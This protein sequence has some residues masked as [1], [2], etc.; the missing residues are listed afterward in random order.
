MF[1]VVRN[2]RKV[3]QI[4]L[5]LIILPFAFFG[6]DSFF[7]DGVSIKDVAKVGD[8]SISLPEFQQALREQQDRIRP[9]LRGQDP[10]MLESPQLKRAVLDNLVQR[11]LLM[12][13]ANKAKLAVSDDQLVRLI[14][15][16]PTLQDNGQFSP[17]LYEALIASRGMSKAM[18]EHNLR[19]DLVV[20]QALMAVGDG[21]LSGST[22]AGRWLGAQMEERE[23]SEAALRPEQYLAGIKVPAEAVKSYYEANRQKFELPE[24]LRAEYLVLSRDKLLEQATVTDEE[25]KAWYQSHGDRYKQAE[26]RNAS[27][28]LIR[29]AKDASADQVKAAETK[30]ADILA[31]VKK[32]PGDFARLAKQHSQDPGSAE[33]GGDLGW[34][35]RGMMVKPFEE[36]V[37]ALKEGQV[38]DVVRSDFGLHVI[39]LTGIH[40]ERSRP[41]DE[42]RGEIVAELKAQ[43]AAKKYA[44]LAESFTNTVYEQPDS[45][46][47][48]AEKFK[49]AV[50]QSDWLA[51]GRGGV[52]P[53]GN[54]KL[55]A[56]LFSDDAI[57]T[58]RNTEAVEVAPSVLVAARVLEHKPAALQPLELVAPTIEKLL[59]HQESVKQAAK[60]GEEKLAQLA[61]GGKADLSWGTPRTVMR[62][63]APNLSA[64]AVRA[65][66][67]ADAGK[68]PAYVGAT[69]PGGA[70]V[71]YR[72][73]RVK[74]YAAGAE[75]KPQAAALRTQYARIVAEEEMSAWISGLKERF[76]VE[77]NKAA[78][79]AKEK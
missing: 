46:A 72:I 33:K 66:F 69:G 40:A 52:G 10:A 63:M 51:K 70:Y 41:L 23:I 9:S 76:P 35:G 19:Q 15:S 24:M 22:T 39:K 49:L 58:K 67:R 42:A 68:L 30:A 28:V 18:F 62:S 5:A 20:Q 73:S 75:E 74:P 29:L 44:E 12:V 8:S 57:K 47:P 56:A 43:Q 13:Y 32:T 27:H 11:R 50:Q 71:L 55:L 54:P 45:L 53:L 77:I 7:R 31:Q 21:S 1:D 65:V 61:G 37:F 78:L 79:E 16:V 38:S 26:E 36:A 59:A 64:E 4:V 3:I 2:N 25:V 14:T 17:Q 60:V 34:F 48:A 6:I